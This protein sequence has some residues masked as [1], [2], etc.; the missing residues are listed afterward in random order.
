MSLASRKLIQAAGAGDTGDD[1]F[2]NVVLLLDGDGTSGDA[3]NTFTDSSTNGFTVTESGSVVQ[4][5]FSPYGDNWSVFFDGS[6]DAIQYSGNTNEFA[7][8][9]GDFTIEA[10]VNFSSISSN[11]YILST[12]D[13]NQG[14]FSFYYDGNNTELRFRNGDAGVTGETFNPETGVWYHVAVSRDNSTLRFFVDGTQLGSDTTNYTQ[15]IQNV[16]TH[17]LQVGRYKLDAQVIEGAYFHGFI[18]NARIIK[19]S[20]LYTSGFTP[21]TSPLTAVTGTEFLGC[22]SNRFVDNSGNSFTQ[23]LNST[24]KVTPFSPFKDDDARDITT[25]GGSA[26]FEYGATNALS[27]PADT[28]LDLSTG[29]FTVEMWVY[30]D[31]KIND[32]KL[33]L[34]WT[35]TSN[36]WQFKYDSSYGWSLQYAGGTWIVNNGSA[37]NVNVGEWQH[38]ALTRSGSNFTIWQNGESFA[39]GT[40]SANIGVYNAKNIGGWTGGSSS[41][42]GYMSDFRLTKGTAL[43][44]S[45]FT[46]PTS[47]ISAGANTELFLKFQDAGIY[48]RSGI[49]NLDTVGNA[50][51]DTAVKK[52]GTGSMQFDG[53]GDYLIADSSNSYNFWIDDA[54][55]TAECWANGTANGT[56]VFLAHGTVSSPSTS[57]WWLETVSGVMKLYIS[58]GSSYTV[59]SDTVAFSTYSGWVHIAFVNSSGTSALYMNGQRKNTAT[60]PTTNTGLSPI[61]VGGSPSGYVFNGYIDD[62]RI[63]KGIARYTGS[64]FTAPTD[65]LLKF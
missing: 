41:I 57:N 29:D 55:Y 21:S 31:S 11:R 19:G 63:T 52:Y 25:D 33:Y 9:T 5:S 1:D 60:T 20:A 38:L 39:T 48:D 36:Y 42:D 6:N 10:W 37:S 34:D 51:I 50:Q 30:L 12:Y 13:G 4:G 32:S 15:N 8:G 56:Q 26:Y 14:G 2:A 27:V 46:P 22:Q 43:Y 3:N 65:A 18:S 62:V 54:D 28:N 24:P 40:S 47:P 58:N 61:L 16:N 17:G 64:S 7:F 44:S 35:N 45:S 23:A 53:S 49:N 59:I